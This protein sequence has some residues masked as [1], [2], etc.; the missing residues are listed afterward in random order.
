MSSNKSS[1]SDS[2]NWIVNGRDL[3]PLSFSLRWMFRF[4]GSVTKEGYGGTVQNTTWYTSDEAHAKLHFI[5]I[6]CRL[7]L[8]KSLVFYAETRPLC[9]YPWTSAHSGIQY[10]DVTG[11]NSTT[12]A[13]TSLR[14]RLICY[15][16]LHNITSLITGIAR[17]ALHFCCSHFS[18]QVVRDFV[19]MTCFLRLTSVYQQDGHNIID[20]IFLFPLDK[21]HLPEN[22]W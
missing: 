13:A 7:L 4:I 8:N 15:T 2:T 5:C 14:H 1:T 20:I 3:T 11:Y 16:S 6:Y 9:L 19:W 17:H 12:S 22:L 10:C 21:G 18:R